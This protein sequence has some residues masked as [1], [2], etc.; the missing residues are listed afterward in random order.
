MSADKIILAKKA[1]RYIGVQQDPLALQAAVGL[2][3]IKN[4]HV[5]PVTLNFSQQMEAKV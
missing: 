5:T 2:S 1:T 3:F 4:L